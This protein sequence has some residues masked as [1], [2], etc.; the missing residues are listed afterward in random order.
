MGG[1]IHGGFGATKGARD[2]AKG[3]QRF[4]SEEAGLIKELERNHKKFQPVRLTGSWP[5]RQ[6]PMQNLW[7]IA[8]SMGQS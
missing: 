1:G 2:V 6:M 7:S 3:K 8:E 4:N 5:P